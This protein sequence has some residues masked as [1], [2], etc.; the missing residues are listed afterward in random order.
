MTRYLLLGLGFCLLLAG[1][2]AAAQEEYNTEA[3][4]GTWADDTASSG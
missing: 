4:W 2:P 3:L 1:L